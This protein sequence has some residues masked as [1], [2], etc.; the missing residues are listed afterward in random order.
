MAFEISWDF[1]WQF[2]GK[3][4]LRE[5]LS[6]AGISKWS[7]KIPQTS[8]IAARALH[9]TQSFKESEKLKQAE[10][11]MCIQVG[12]YISEKSALFQKLSF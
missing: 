2:K 8:T 12:S 4:I 9:L 5:L 10:E 7:D 11:K 6:F 3:S 1:L